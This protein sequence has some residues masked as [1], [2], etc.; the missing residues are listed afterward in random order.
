MIL[1]ARLNKLSKSKEE[2]KA[3]ISC[4]WAI[5]HAIPIHSVLYISI[6]LGFTEQASAHYTVIE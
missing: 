5:S 2:W 3:M 4:L 1:M 6:Y